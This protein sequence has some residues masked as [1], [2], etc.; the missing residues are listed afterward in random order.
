[1][2]YADDVDIGGEIVVTKQ[3]NT[4]CLLDASE[5]IGLEVNPEKTK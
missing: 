1:V 3:T 4:Q 5:E 2:S